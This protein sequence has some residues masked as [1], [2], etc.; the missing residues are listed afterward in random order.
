M[1]YKEVSAFAQ[2]LALKQVLIRERWTNASSLA[3]EQELRDF[4]KAEGNA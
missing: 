4:A 1:R 2:Q 3:L